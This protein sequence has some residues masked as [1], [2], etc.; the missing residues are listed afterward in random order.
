MAVTNT[1]KSGLKYYGYYQ[2]ITNLIIGLIILGIGLYIAF[3]KYKR[4]KFVNAKVIN[5]EIDCDKNRKKDNVS[6]NC[7]LKL[8]YTAGGKKY[9]EEYTYKSAVKKYTNDK[10]GIRYDPNNPTSFDTFPFNPKY[11]GYAMIVFAILTI[12]YS[13]TCMSFPVMCGGFAAAR[14]I[15]SAITP[16]SRT[17]VAKRGISAPGGWSAT[18]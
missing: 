7:R 12:L 6:Y 8:E 13:F 11:I 18:W 10:V 17:S 14:N 4:T 5:E 15:K 3:K 2:S 1:V 16:R 9:I